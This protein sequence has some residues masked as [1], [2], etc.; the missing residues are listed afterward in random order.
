MLFAAVQFDKRRKKVPNNVR[1]P[2]H[3][4]YGGGNCEV[5]GKTLVVVE[6]IRRLV[7]RSNRC[8][9]LTAKKDHRFLQL[10]PGLIQQLSCFRHGVLRLICLSGGR[11]AA[12]RKYSGNINVVIVRLAQSKPVSGCSGRTSFLFALEK[13]DDFS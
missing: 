5:T 3:Q 11:K 13:G 7:P 9:R 8:D 6:R 4:E 12:R 1:A 2:A 10:L